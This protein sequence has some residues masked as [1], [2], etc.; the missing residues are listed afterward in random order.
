M[1]K[2]FRSVGEKQDN[3]K[4]DVEIIQSL[5]NTHISNGKLAMQ[6]IDLLKEDGSYGKNTKKAI[7]AFQLRMFVRPDGIISPTGPTLV[8]LNKT[9]SF[10]DF[11]AVQAITLLGLHKGPPKTSGMDSIPSD[12]WNTAL[13]KLT[14]QS[15][16][17]LIDKPEIATLIDFRLPKTKRRMWIVDLKRHVIEFNVVVSHGSGSRLKKTRRKDDPRFGNKKGS[18]KSSLG[19]YATFYTRNAKAGSKNKSKSRIALV[20]EGL[21]ETNKAA[22]RRGILFH[23]AHYVSATRAGNSQGCFATEQSVNDKLVPFIKAGSF[24]YAYA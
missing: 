9:P 18:N 20:V 11:G 8:E 21:E 24:V 5:L 4:N 6:N 16:N 3:K 13:T 19:C 15:N 2:I 17:S 7:N 1:A 14:S 22:R 23:G 12:L 10:P